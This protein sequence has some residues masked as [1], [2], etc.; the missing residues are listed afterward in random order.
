MP[1][2]LV[3]EE[4]PPPPV[5]IPPKKHQR[6]ERSRRRR[7]ALIAVLVMLLVGLAAAWG[8]KLLADHYLKHVPKVVGESQLVAKHELESAGYDVKVYFRYSDSVTKGLVISTDPAAGHRLSAGSTVSMTVSSGPQ[9]YDVPS[10]VNKSPDDA[11][12]ILK[13]AG[14]LNI[15]DTIKR[16]SS[17]SVP[18]G[19]V[20]RTDPAAGTRVTTERTITIYVSSGPPVIDVPNITPG[21]PFDDAKKALKDAG[22][23]V[24]EVEQYSDSIDRGQV[25]SVNPSDR[26][27]KGSTVTVAVSKG[28][29][30]V[31]I[32][33]FP[34]FPPVADVTSTL[35]GLGLHVKIDKHGDLGRVVQLD[36]PSGTTVQAGAT[37]TVTVY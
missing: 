4:V 16:E 28:P 25:I 19:K 26:A 35:E 9:L 32:P 29:Q 36:P 27:R 23:K 13:S 2:P 24:S 18:N 31:T 34:L 1:L 20:T 8:G 12:R 22:F 30:F 7:R 10:V 21:T 3:E 15:S 37:V 14:P 11:I 5:V 17:E 6:S 33:D